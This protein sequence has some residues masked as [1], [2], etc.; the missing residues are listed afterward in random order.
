MSAGYG[1]VSEFD[2]YR[3]N[4]DLRETLLATSSPLALHIF[5]FQYAGEIRKSGGLRGLGAKSKQIPLS[6]AIRDEVASFYARLSHHSIDMERDRHST[7][8]YKIVGSIGRLYCFF[9]S[10]SNYASNR[11]SYFAGGLHP[12]DITYGSQ[13]VGRGETVFSLHLTSFRFDV[14]HWRSTFIFITFNVSS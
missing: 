10:F 2:F 4:A 6:V 11:R 14:P 7:S 13:E 3:I 12:Q 5:Q 8:T 9:C 1:R